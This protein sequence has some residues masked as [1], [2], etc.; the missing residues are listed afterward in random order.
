MLCA[1]AVAIVGFM[2]YKGAQ[3]LRPALLVEHPQPG[4]DQAKTGGFLDPILGTCRC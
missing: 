3:Y 1:I 4:L 2:A